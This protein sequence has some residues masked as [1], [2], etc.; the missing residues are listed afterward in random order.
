MFLACRALKL[1]LR[2]A[3]ALVLVFLPSLQLLLQL[4]LLPGKVASEQT[5]RAVVHQGLQDGVFHELA[6]DDHRP[7]LAQ[8]LV[9]AV[10]GVLAAVVAPG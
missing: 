8:S 4:V 2:C 6:F 10:L 5:Q 1:A 9:V 7:R 3:S